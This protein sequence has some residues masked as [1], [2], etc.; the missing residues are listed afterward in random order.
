MKYTEP[1]TEKSFQFDLIERNKIRNSPY[2]RDFSSTLTN[3]IL[4]SVTYGFVIPIVVTEDGDS[5]LVIDGQH[6][7]GAMDKAISESNPL[8][9]AIILPKEF[10][11][12]PLF[13]N[14]EKGDNIKDKSVK[15]HRLYLD[16]LSQGGWTERDL[17]PSV[18]YEP[19]IFTIAFSFCENGL[20]SPSLVESP[21]KKLD[22]KEITTFDDNGYMTGMNLQESVEMRRYRGGL[23]KQLEDTVLEIADEWFVTD[24]NLK[25]SIV[26]Q[27]SQQLW[28]RKRNLGIEPEEGLPALIEQIRL[29][30]WSWMSNR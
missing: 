4:N 7:L 13:Y 30:D 9:P 23:A 5:Y 22:N 25:K 24:F 20:K 19:Y 11:D 18:N 3:K 17:L 26:S 1:V 29:M 10:E 21:V 8:V 14:I 27:A 28:G 15:I 2:Q 16:K 12:F 6:R